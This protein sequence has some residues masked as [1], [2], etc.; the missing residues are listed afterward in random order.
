MRRPTR[1]VSAAELRRLFN[2]GRYHERAQANQLLISVE[3]EREARDSAGQPPGTLSQMVW[4][5]DPSTLD[6]VALVHQYRRPD[7]SIGGSGRPDPKRLLLQDE[8]L[9]L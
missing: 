2:E 1:K 5:F 3:S 6:R 4:Y 9:F 8:I 7:G